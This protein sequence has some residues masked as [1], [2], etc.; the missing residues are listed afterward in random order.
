MRLIQLI[1]CFAI[2]ATLI[3]CGGSGASGDPANSGAPNTTKRQPPASPQEAE[4]STAPHVSVPAGPPPKKIVIEELKR[5]HGPPV[6]VGQ[7]FTINFVGVYYKTGKPFETHWG[8]SP[9]VWHFGTNELVKGLEIGL[10][11]MRVGGRRKLIV[12]SRLAYKSGA[13][14]Y[15]VEM[16]AL[17]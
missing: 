5:G 7:V 12:P 9:F 1:G 17:E 16:L 11:G 10:K 2:S 3:S 4:A 13:R 15:L 8:K 6:K 14:V